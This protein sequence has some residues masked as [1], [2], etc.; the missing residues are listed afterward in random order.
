MKIVVITLKVSPNYGGILQA[1]SLQKAIE[2]LG[3]ECVLID[4]MN[5]EF[6][7]K[8]TFFG[9]P[10]GMSI[11]YSLFKKAQ[12]PLMTLMMKRMMSFYRYMNLTRHFEKPNELTELNNIYDVFV[13]ALIKCGLTI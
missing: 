3:H 9:K 8:F 4:Y 1:Y 2:K 10:T 6:R 11:L 13:T 5:N 7:H 12:Y